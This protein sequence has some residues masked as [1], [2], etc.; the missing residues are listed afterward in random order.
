MAP[1]VSQSVQ[2]HPVTTFYLLAFTLS[3]AGWVPRLAA[4]RGVAF[5]A[6]PL[7]QAS[8]ILPAIGPAVAVALTMRLARE[9]GGFGPRLRTWFRWRVNARWCWF[10][11]V[12]PPVLLLASRAVSRGLPYAAPVVGP[13][14]SA[15]DILVFGLMSL[16]ANPWE[17]VGWRGFALARLQA[18]Y[19]AAVATLLVGV[20]WAA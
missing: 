4:A 11:V 9:P 2:A 19:P 8:L 5:F 7:W 15:G 18:R 6:S 12:A 14:L 13:P 20:L 17:E 1:R 3:W 10:A 16:L